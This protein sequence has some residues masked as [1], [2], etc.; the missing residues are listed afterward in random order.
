M[1][2]K[3]LE[4]NRE[5]S[6]RTRE[7]D[8]E[9]FTRRAQR[10]DPEYFW[11]GCADSRV[12]TNVVVGLEPGEIFVH[13]N[14]ANV[15]HSTDLS[16]LS[17]LEYAVDALAIDKIIICGH[18]GCGGVRAATEDAP[19]GLADHW[20]EPIRRL[21]RQYAGELD[22]LAEPEARRDRLAELNVIHSVARIAETPIL[23]RAWERGRDVH[24]HGVIYSLHDGLLEQLDC[25]VGPPAY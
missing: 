19:H 21:A 1:V 18:Y 22:A 12:P 16:L 24:I 2:D 6:R 13:R 25:T 20:L 10:Q 23:R 5:W 15:V 17:A 8:P 7:Q 4:Q 9:Y 14:V 11:V 3:L